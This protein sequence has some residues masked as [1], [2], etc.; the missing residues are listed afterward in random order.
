MHHARAVVLVLVGSVAYAESHGYILCPSPRQR[1]DEKVADWT[2]WQGIGNAVH[3]ETGSY[4]PGEANA[5]NLNAG[6]GGGVNFV[7]GAE[8]GSHGLVRCAH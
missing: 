2:H 4:Y 7:W 8:P 3:G 1:R 5:A 6:I